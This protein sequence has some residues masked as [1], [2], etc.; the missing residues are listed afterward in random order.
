MPPGTV[1]DLVLLTVAGGGA[2]VVYGLLLRQTGLPEVDALLAAVRQ[3]LRR[4][5]I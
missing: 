5:A 3:R 2:V 4:S 1:H